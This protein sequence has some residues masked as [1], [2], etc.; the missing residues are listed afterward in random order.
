[1][2][3]KIWKKD[4]YFLIGGKRI[5][6]DPSVVKL[7]EEGRVLLTWG[8]DFDNVSN[9]M[10]WANNIVLEDGEILCDLEFNDVVVEPEILDMLSDETNMAR[11]GGYYTG[12]EQYTDAKGGEHVIS[13]ELKSV[14][15]I[16]NPGFPPANLVPVE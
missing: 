13:C 9:I 2:S 14:A 11:L 7:P 6:M 15:F 4:D 5:D 8:Y 1:M 16:L 10:G 3:E 12:V